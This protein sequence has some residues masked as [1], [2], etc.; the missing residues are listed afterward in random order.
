MLTGPSSSAS[1]DAEVPL[2][3]AEWLGASFVDGDAIARCH[4]DDL[5]AA[6]VLTRCAPPSVLEPATLSEAL[7]PPDPGFASWSAFW[8]GD[9]GY[10]L[11]GRRG[12]GL[13]DEWFACTLTTPAHD[14][15]GDAVREATAATAATAVSSDASPQARAGRDVARTML[16]GRRPLGSD[17][18]ARWS[19]AWRR[20]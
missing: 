2:P 19:V 5:P 12:E 1:A 11:C 20:A 15:T 4:G 6:I 8:N 16:V 9:E 10:V 7:L 13:P 3:I 17:R 14:A 18:V